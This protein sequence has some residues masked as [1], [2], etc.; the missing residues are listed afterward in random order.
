MTGTGT[1]RYVP[2]SIERNRS[3]PKSCAHLARNT[4]CP[5]IL[6]ARSPERL[7]PMPCRCCRMKSSHEMDSVPIVCNSCSIDS[8]SH[9]THSWDNYMN[10]ARP[11]LCTVHCFF[12]FQSVGGSFRWCVNDVVCRHITQA[13]HVIKIKTKQKQKRES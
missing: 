2:Q 12:P 11:I 4:L 13:K 8:N 3:N 1:L 5:S 6:P 10:L 9:T 7:Q